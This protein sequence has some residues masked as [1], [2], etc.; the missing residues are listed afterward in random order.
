MFFQKS[1]IYPFYGLPFSGMKDKI[2]FCETLIY[3]LL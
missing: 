2:L 3:K 1:K